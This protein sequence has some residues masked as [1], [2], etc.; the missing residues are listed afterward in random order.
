LTGFAGTQ[1][2]ASSRSAWTVAARGWAFR[3]GGP[4]STR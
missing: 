1:T 2:S 4:T 3:R